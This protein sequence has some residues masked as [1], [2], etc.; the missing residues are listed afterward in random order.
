MTQTVTG[1]INAKPGLGLKPNSRRNASI[2]INQEAQAPVH[3]NIVEGYSATHGRKAI[4]QID[5]L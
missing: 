3:A 1:K 5:R 4:A 2:I